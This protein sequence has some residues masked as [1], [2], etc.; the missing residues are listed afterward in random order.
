MAELDANAFYVKHPLVTVASS[1]DRCILAQPLGRPIVFEGAEAEAVSGLLASLLEPIEGRMLR[2]RHG[3]DAGQLEALLGRLLDQRMVLSAP[4]RAMSGVPGW[5]GSRPR[6]PRCE[7]L[8]V[9]VTGGVLA[10]A[11]FPY[12]DQVWSRL[13]PNLDVI[14][15]QAALRFVQPRTFEYLYRARVWV[16]PFAMQGEVT[17]PHIHLAE[18]SELVVVLPATAHSLHRLASGACSDLLSLVVAATA[19]P[20]V[21]VPTMNQ[22]MWRHPPIQ[23]NVARLRQDGMYVVEPTV[24]REVSAPRDA[25]PQ[26][27]G[28][29]VDPMRLVDLL[30]VILATRDAERSAPEQGEAQREP[31]AARVSPHHTSTGPQP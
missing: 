20:V 15:T 6:P 25:P 21:L 24:G 17:V 7:R 9:A 3:S 22:A 30:E 14:L 29:G 4:D 16:D 2:A 23:R 12:L 26:I 28:P 19:A 31:G 8:T 27:G 10:A 11:I 18:S 1:A 13:C 5:G